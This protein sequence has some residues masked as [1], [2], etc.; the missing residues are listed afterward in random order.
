MRRNIFLALFICVMV[1]IGIVVITVGRNL[2]NDNLQRDIERNGKQLQ[3]LCER[4]K[5]SVGKGTYPETIFEL[6]HS[7][8]VWGRDR[9][10]NPYTDTSIRISDDRDTPFEPGNLLYVV[11]SRNDRHMPNGYKIYMLGRKTDPFYD[12]KKALVWQKEYE[13]FASKAKSPDNIVMVFEH[14]KVD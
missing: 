10:R 11:T 2:A 7:G 5:G 4:Y 8:N 3:R 9:M 14:N 6:F 13:K 1:L 12:E